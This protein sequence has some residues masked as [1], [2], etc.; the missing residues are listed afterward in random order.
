MDKTLI[1]TGGMYWKKHYRYEKKK[2]KIEWI[3]NS[4]KNN[5]RSLTTILPIWFDESGMNM[6]LGISS[7]PRKS[8]LVNF[9][10]FFSY[11]NLNTNRLKTIREIFRIVNPVL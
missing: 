8:H 5:V 6:G 4:V 10:L 9:S 2:K 3:L 1:E 11:F 7:I